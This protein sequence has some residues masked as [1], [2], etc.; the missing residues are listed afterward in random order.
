M[1]FVVSDDDERATLRSFISERLMRLTGTGATYSWRIYTANER[2]DQADVLIA[3]PSD[4]RYGN[5]VNQYPTFFEEVSN[6]VFIDCDRMISLDS[7][8][9]PVMATQLQRASGER[10][11][12]LFL[13]QDLYKGFAAR[14]LPKFFCTEAVLTFSS[15]KETSPFPTC[16][17]TVRARAT[18]FT[19]ETVRR[20][21][22]LSA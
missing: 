16:S 20:P 1:I 14:S 5:L 2:L 8:L 17:G 18:E 3:S 12:F 10:I 15:A 21:P 6:A 4:F 19:T 9:C 7:Y 22:A 11:R 13:T